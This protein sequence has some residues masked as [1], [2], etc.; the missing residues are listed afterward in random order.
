MGE[1]PTSTKVN[2][3]FYDMMKKVEV[4]TT[5]SANSK[6]PKKTVTSTI[7]PELNKC[8]TLLNKQCNC[9]FWSPVGRLIVLAGLGD[10][11]SGTL[12]F[13]DAVAD[14]T[15]TSKDH[16]RANAVLWDPS[17]RMVA[18]TVTHPIEGGH[19]KFAMDNGYILWSFQGRQLSNKSFE[20][21]YQFVWRPRE[22][23]LT[24]KECG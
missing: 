11:A 23:L 10:A 9:L 21:F 17:G 2:V 24:A 5:S 3:S 1:N 19:F 16:Y 7:V 8:T 6:K 4:T 15:L 13:Y 18:T 14:Q 22:E 20:N 12:E